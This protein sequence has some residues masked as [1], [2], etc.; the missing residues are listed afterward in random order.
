MRIGAWAGLLAAFCSAGCLSLTPIQAK[1]RVELAPQEGDAGQVQVDAID[2]SVSYVHEGLRLRVEHL[3]ADRPIRKLVQSLDTWIHSR[4]P[5]TVDGNLDEV[6][7]V[8]R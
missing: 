6:I 7:W 8:R 3:S 1:H 5:V 4:V 2:N